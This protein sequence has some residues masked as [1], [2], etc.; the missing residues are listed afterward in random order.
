MGGQF[1]NWLYQKLESMQK[2]PTG[3]LYN[4]A[5]RE[6]LQT[7]EPASNTLSRQK[8]YVIQKLSLCSIVVVCGVVMSVVMW[9]NE[10]ME[11]RIVDNQI[12]R[13]EYGDGEK[14]VLLIAEDMENSYEIP[15][16]V[17]ERCY[18]QE[19]LTQMS[20]EAAAAL[21]TSILGENKSLD[22]IEYDMDLIS[23]VP[24]HPFSV[25]WHTDEMYL[26]DT[27]HLVQDR[28][29]APVLT[30]LTAILSYES[31]EAEYN[32]TVK[33]H[34]K[35]VQPSIEARLAKQLLD[36]EAESREQYN[37]ILPLEI[38]DKAIQWS[39]KRSWNGLLLLGATP[40]LAILIYYGK[41]K[42][43]HRQ[44]VDRKEQMC[45]DYPEIVSS[46]ALLIG[47]GMTVPNAWNKIAKDYRK[48]RDEGN[49]KRFAYEE[50]LLAIY[51]MENGVVQV[52]AYERFGRRC[53]IPSYNKLS[54]MLSQN[55]R[56]GAA[57]LPQLL[58]EEAAEAFEERKH[59]ARKTGEKAGTKLL[60][61]MML[62][63]G[64]TMVIIMVPALTS[65]L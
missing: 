7:L 56:K 47:A 60:V 30:N 59:A 53:R 4:S 65:Y 31:F 46:L 26:D 64:I 63:L 58:K 57:N 15:L 38:E 33:I 17:S 62:L 28:L 8:E 21:E 2:K 16:T 20:I 32:L 11:T 25:E 27:G 22:Q 10:K 3:I 23:K 37:I 14:S 42:D 51:E 1:A 45:M 35:A 19:E 34:S 6:D 48:R 54:T 36:M 29:A 40:V 9:I 52:K 13:G 18:S 55:I 39:Y 41:D 44:V 12:V 61:P 49:R 43:L 5:V 50:M 24:E